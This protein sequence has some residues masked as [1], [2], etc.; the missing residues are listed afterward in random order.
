[1]KFNWIAA[2]VNALHIDRNAN[3]GVHSGTVL[4]FDRNSPFTNEKTYYSFRPKPF[5]S[6]HGVSKAVLPAE[7]AFKVELTCMPGTTSDLCAK[8]EQGLKN[9]GKRLLQTLRITKQIILKASFKSFCAGQNL[10][11]CSRR[12]TLGGAR[13]ASEF[14]IKD[15]TDFY[16][17]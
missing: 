14:V 13:A 3:T 5:T 9:A 16:S 2:I 15:G 8:A 17:T 11:T 7:D 10:T 4:R 12:N 1:M 6:F